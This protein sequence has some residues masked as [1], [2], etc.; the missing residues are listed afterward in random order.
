MRLK[1]PV[2]VVSALMVFGL[3]TVIVAAPPQ[4]KVTVPSKFTPP[5]R[6]AFS[7]PSVQ[8]PL[9]P[10]TTTHA[11]AREDRV[12]PCRSRANPTPLP[13]SVLFVISVAVPYARRRSPVTAP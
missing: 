5:G 10:V 4:A 11:R 8:P 7:A 2:I 12:K 9:V 13:R 1:A 6:Q 3:V